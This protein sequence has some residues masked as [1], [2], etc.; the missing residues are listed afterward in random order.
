MN[1]VVLQIPVSA[2]LRKAAEVEAREQ[3]F[4]SLQDAVRMFLN[5]LASKMIEVRLGESIQLSK[6]N[7]SR[8]EKMVEDV[9]KG[10]V[11]TQA[12]DNVDALMKHLNK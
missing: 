11:K 6:R 4:S 5:K 10:R 3:G 1:R 12:F 2:D 9:E 7:A 8:Y